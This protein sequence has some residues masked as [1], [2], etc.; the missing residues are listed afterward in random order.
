MKTHEAVDGK[1][2]MFF[3]GP[4][5]SQA[6]KKMGINLPLEYDESRLAELEILKIKAASAKSSPSA[7]MTWAEYPVKYRADKDPL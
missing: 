2:H 5:D 7:D 3:D 1:E 4:Q 6:I